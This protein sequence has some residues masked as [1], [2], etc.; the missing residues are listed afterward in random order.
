MVREK[1]KMQMRKGDLLECCCPPGGKEGRGP[2]LQR[3][4]GTYVGEGYF[5]MFPESRLGTW[6]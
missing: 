2:E 5:S 4:V 6:C 1:L 3:R